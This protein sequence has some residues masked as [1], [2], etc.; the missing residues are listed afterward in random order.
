MLKE[1]YQMPNKKEVIKQYFQQVKDEETG[2][3]KKGFTYP[4]QY[5]SELKKQ[6][7]SSECK[8]KISGNFPIKY[9]KNNY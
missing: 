4:K 6:S 2:E 8:M 7:Y 9:I 5:V 1:I 3:I